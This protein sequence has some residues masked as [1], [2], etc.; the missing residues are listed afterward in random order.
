MLYPVR[1]KIRALHRWDLSPREA[2]K[3]QLKLR[4]LVVECGAIRK[5]GF[6]AGADHCGLALAGI[7]VDE[8]T[9]N[10]LYKAIIVRRT[11]GTT[12]IAVSI[13]FNCNGKDM[14]S[15]IPCECADFSISVK[16]AAVIEELQ[17]LRNGDETEVVKVSKKEFT[18][19]WSV[20][21][22]ENNEF[23]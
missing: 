10:A 2:V 17:I 13:D 12:G 1:M 11:F 21:N 15:I 18:H 7:P 20:K 6:I 8:L 23:W 14:G 19:T 4:N 16:G 22:I 9:R 3:M 5:I